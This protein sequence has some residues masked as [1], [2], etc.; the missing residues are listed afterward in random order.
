[1]KKKLVFVA[2]FILMAWSVNSC[3]KISCQF[4]KLV[5]RDSGGAVVTSGSETEYCD[6]DLAVIKATPTV[7]DPI[8]GSKTKY[9]C[10]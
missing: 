10:R 6:A 7:T 3:N 2:A 9:E 5:T 4:C 8:T 1:M